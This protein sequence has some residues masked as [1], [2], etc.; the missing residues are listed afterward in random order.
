MFSDGHASPLAFCNLNQR[1]IANVVVY[2]TTKRRMPKKEKAYEVIPGAQGSL[3][4]SSNN[5]F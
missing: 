1:S 4:Q 5:Y 3:I 2:R